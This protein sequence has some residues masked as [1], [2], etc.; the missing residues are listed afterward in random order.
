VR[1]RKDLCDLGADA[2]PRTIAWHIH[3]FEGSPPSPATICRILARRRF[4][5]SGPRK[6]PQS[7][8]V[9]FEADRPND[10][11]QGDVTHWTLPDGSG[12]ET[13]NFMDDHSRLVLV[14]DVRRVTEGPRP[15]ESS[16][17]GPRLPRGSWPS[18]T[19]PGRS[20]K[21]SD[22]SMPSSSTTT[23]VARIGPGEGSRR[24][25]P[26]PTGNE[27]S[28]ACPRWIPRTA[29]ATTR[30]SP[31]T[32]SATGSATRC[33]TSAWASLAGNTGP[34]LHRRRSRP[35]RLRGRRAVGRDDDRPVEGRPEHANTPVK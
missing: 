12:V 29:S 16:S 6:R 8:F 22:R 28:P 20:A 7:S 3:Q 18:G 35:G 5:T 10:C 4:F 14:A 17:A 21:S 25:P 2:G 33:R 15:A 26:S 32:R 1:L 24:R 30:P 11:W 23:S 27:P 13:L 34:P 9:R 19:R 31:T